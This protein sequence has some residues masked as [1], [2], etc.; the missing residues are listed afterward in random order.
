MNIITCSFTGGGG[1]LFNQ[2]VR[3]I[4]SS[5]ICKEHNKK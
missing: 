2:I 1:R 3:N 5:I 4:A